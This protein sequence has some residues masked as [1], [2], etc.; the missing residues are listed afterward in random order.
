MRKKKTKIK[1]SYSVA[2]ADTGR[3]VETQRMKEMWFFS[4]LQWHGAGIQPYRRC[5]CRRTTD[6][7]VTS[8]I[9]PLSTSFH[10]LLL[11]VSIALVRNSFT[12]AWTRRREHNTHLK[13]IHPQDVL[14]NKV[15]G[16][17][18]ATTKCAYQLNELTKFI[19]SFFVPESDSIAPAK[20]LANANTVSART[21]RKGIEINAKNDIPMWRSTNE[22]WQWQVKIGFRTHAAAI[23]YGKG[24]E[25]IFNSENAAVFPSSMSGWGEK[26]NGF[27]NLWISF[28]FQFYS[29]GFIAI[30]PAFPLN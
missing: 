6:T 3:G 7:M 30:V 1:H 21:I 27:S 5:W 17:F 25:N 15:N 11:I 4:Q 26:K 23:S 19:K 22:S 29:N 10:C 24:D 16:K 9:L 28:F 20:G 8:P 12:Y 14:R 13:A 2:A 18:H